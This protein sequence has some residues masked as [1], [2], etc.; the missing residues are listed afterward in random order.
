MS[1]SEGEIRERSCKL[2]KSVDIQILERMG[3]CRCRLITKG[4]N[5]KEIFCSVYILR[6]TRSPAI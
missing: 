3:L 2:Y 4:N 6:R 5:Q 1:E